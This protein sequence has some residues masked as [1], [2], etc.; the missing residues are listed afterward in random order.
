MIVFALALA[1]MQAPAAPPPAPPEI[2]TGQDAINDRPFAHITVRGVR[3]ERLEISCRAPNWGDID[4]AYHSRHWLARGNFLTGAQPVT[5]RFDDERARRRLWHVRDR[6]ANFDD[7]GRAIEFLQAMLRAQRL[8]LR[9]RNVENRTFDS[10]FA[11][12]DSRAAI[13]R[14]LATCGSRRFNPRVL[15]ETAP[16]P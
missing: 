3:G 7:R 9:T 13:E 4:I 11:I 5:I 10:V 16:I 1:A 12:G 2:V 6:T 14:L 8:T 15:G